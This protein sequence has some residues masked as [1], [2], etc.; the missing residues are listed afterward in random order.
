[1]AST[2]ESTPVTAA[3]LSESQ[4]ASTILV[5][6]VRASYQRNEKP[7]KRASWRVLLNENTIM[8]SSGR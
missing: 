4:K 7:V 8:N 6:R 3:T 5:S 2:A 1:M